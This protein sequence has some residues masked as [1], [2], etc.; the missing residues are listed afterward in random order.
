[1]AEFY[2]T[3]TVGDRRSSLQAFRAGATWVYADSLETFVAGTSA[4]AEAVARVL[5]TQPITQFG[6]LCTLCGKDG[7]LQGLERDYFSFLANLACAQGNAEKLL[8]KAESEAVYVTY[9]GKSRVAEIA[10]ILDRLEGTLQTVGLVR[11][12]T[13]SRDIF[14]EAKGSYYWVQ[15][16]LESLV[17]LGLAAHK[18]KWSVC[19]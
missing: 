18:D 4:H 12:K 14:A 13:A 1:L 3:R 17:Y 11:F 15:S 6:Y 9:V 19:R 16:M 8:C 5:A 10:K 2:T 7:D